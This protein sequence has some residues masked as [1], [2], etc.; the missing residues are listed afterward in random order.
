[1]V[2]L[3]QNLRVKKGNLSRQLLKGRRYT[4]NCQRQLKKG[5]N[6]ISSQGASS[7]GLIGGDAVTDSEVVSKGRQD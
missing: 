6:S 2:I 1:M 7:G 4:Q 3:A 5:A